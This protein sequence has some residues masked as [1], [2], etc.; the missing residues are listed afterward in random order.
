MASESFHGVSI[1][2]QGGPRGSEQWYTWCTGTL[3][4]DL[5]S[6][7]LAFTPADRPE[8]KKPLG[9]L[10]CAMQEA[11]DGQQLCGKNV[12]LNAF[13]IH[14]DNQVHPTLLRALFH[15]ATDE[16]GFSQIARRAEEISARRRRSSGRPGAAPA[17]L[18]PER[19]RDNSVMER[20]RRHLCSE[21]GWPPLL[22]PDCELYGPAGGGIN[23]GEVL[24][25]RGVVAIVDSNDSS[26]VGEYKVLFQDEAAQLQWMIG[27]HTRLQQMPSEE[28]PSPG[29]EGRGHCCHSYLFSPDGH[30]CLSLVFDDSDIVLTFAR[31]LV[32]R[33][34]LICLASMT[35]KGQ[36]AK[37]L[38]VGEVDLLK[39]RLLLP[40]L[41][42]WILKGFLFILGVV[43][44]HASMMYINNPESHSAVDVLRLA[45]SDLHSVASFGLSA[46]ADSVVGA[47]RLI[48]PEPGRL[49]EANDFASTLSTGTRLPDVEDIW[50]SDR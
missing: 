12:L 45:F 25:G 21:N 50:A 23:H 30:A 18:L 15:S 48:V 1:S 32:V 19:P 6:L 4:C 17:L 43:F 39:S 13:T 5:A 49:P 33:Q 40:T 22:F 28:L 3:D 20:L 35:A 42:R 46:G 14:T 10:T 11:V 8:L 31:D 38:L 26:R 37:D 47:C 16:E 7:N 24:L 44:L 27:P 41:R 36:K 29:S 9:R 2:V 34:R